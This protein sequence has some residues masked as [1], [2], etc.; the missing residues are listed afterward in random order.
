M[1]AEADLAYVAATV[2]ADGCEEVVEA[3][4]EARVGEVEGVRLVEDR[5][6]FAVDEV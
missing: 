2:R 5:R 3:G 6:C 4:F 1:V